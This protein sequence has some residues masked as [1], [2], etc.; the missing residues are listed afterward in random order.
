MYYYPY[1]CMELNFTASNA[2][3]AK[4]KNWRQ[5]SVGGLMSPDR[6]DS[7]DQGTLFPSGNSPGNPPGNPVKK[8]QILVRPPSPVSPY[9]GASGLK[10][11]RSFS[12]KGVKLQRLSIP[13]KSRYIFTFVFFWIQI[14]IVFY[15]LIQQKWYFVTKIVLIYCEKKLSQ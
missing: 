4:P 3:S 12:L 6:G 15:K 5:F 8:P 14:W 1:F 11:S 2:T 7:Q 13:N 10:K 9:S